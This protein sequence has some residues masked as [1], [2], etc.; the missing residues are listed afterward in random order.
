ML[1]SIKFKLL[2]WLLIIFSFIFTILGL[3][4]DY[5]LEVVIF[6][7]LDRSLTHT[8][9]T[10]GNPLIMEASHGQLPM[11]LWELANITT[12]I[13][14]ERLSGH[15]Y[16]ITSLKGEVLSRSPSLGLADI[17]LPIAGASAIPT[18]KTIRGPN[19]VPLRLISQ[20]LVLPDESTL[21]LEVG[22]T[23]E[24]T[25]T[26]LRSFRDIVIIVFPAIFVLSAIGG[27][28]ITGWSLR[29]LK[30]FSSKIGQI[31]EENLNTRIED[32]RVAR[33]LKPL[34]ESFNTMLIRIE[35]A[36]QRQQQFLSDASHELR[37]PTSIIKS[38]CDVTLSR[39]RT[40]N[41]YKEAMIKVGESVNRMCDI[42]N[43]ILIVSRLDNKTLKLK[44]VRIDL[45]E[46]MKDVIKII[47]PAA[48]N[49][50]IKMSLD[51]RSVVIRGDTEGITAVFT[52]IVE[53][54]IKYN[55]PGGNI[56]INVDEENNQAIVTV[57]DTGIG[58]PSEEIPKIFERFYRVDTSRGQTVGS[59]LGLSIVKGIIEAHGGRID[60]ESAV[61]KGSTFRIFLPLS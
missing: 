59:G 13:F 17:T 32:V 43:R 56:H 20:S 26:V 54:G 9:Q 10:V 50:D 33:E 27:L 28:I 6:D 39:E 57:R 47:E 45:M 4:L 5:E 60:V 25:Y 53:N 2:I 15:Y 52:N 18:F 42:I 58:I 46:V 7:Q 11:E 38:Y 8:L 1:N 40:A 14:S 31:T 22:V 19:N 35:D 55:K 48:A 16:Q 23:L 44:P 30:M 49:R 12:G 21:I 61:G 37:T 24:D 34:A 29:P 36:F 41:D 51:G 3:F